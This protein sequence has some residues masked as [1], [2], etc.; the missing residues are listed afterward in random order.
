MILQRIRIIVGDAR[1]EPRTSAPEVW[2]STNKPTHLQ[3][4]YLRT[5]K[6]CRKSLNTVLQ[7]FNKNLIRMKENF[8]YHLY[9]FLKPFKDNFNVKIWAESDPSYEFRSG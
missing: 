9:Y 3:D 8:K 7:I 6:N 5:Q 4:T 2:C 1:F